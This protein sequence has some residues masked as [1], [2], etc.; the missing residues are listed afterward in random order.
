MQIKFMIK[1]N[2]DVPDLVKEYAEGKVSMLEKLIN[3]ENDET[4]FD[5][6]FQQ[7]PPAGEY[8]ADITV[9][10]GSLRKH[11]VGRGET[12]QAAIDV[13]KDELERRLRRDKKKRLAVFRRGAR[14]IKEMFRF[15]K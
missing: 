6:E 2:I 1:S 12:L 7:E 11:A 15:E 4:Q 13:A 9:Y 10:S 8:R 5:I 14:K 3:N